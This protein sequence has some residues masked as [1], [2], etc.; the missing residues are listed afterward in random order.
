MPIQ[1][2][3]SVGDVGIIKD[4]SAHEL[5]I[6]AW[7]DGNNVEFVNGYVKQCLGYS[8]YTA[9]GT[10]YDVLHM[11]VYPSLSSPSGSYTIAASGSDLYAA[12]T[13]TF[14][15]ITRS[16]GG[17]YSGQYNSWTSTVLS[18]I[19]IL[20]EGVNVPQYW[21]SN[22]AHVFAPL[23]NWPA[24]YTCA[25]LRAYKNYLFALGVV[26]S[27]T[28]YPYLVK[29]SHPADPGSVPISW[30]QSDPSIDAGEFDLSDSGGYVIDGL[31]LRDS[32]IIYK[33]NSAWRTDYI[34]GAFVFKFSRI[35]GLDGIANRNCVVDIG[36]RHVVLTNNDLV[37]HDG[38]NV[39]SVLSNRVRADF[40]S[41]LYFEAS[42]S[43][44]GTLAHLF[45][46]P[47][48]RSVY[49]AYLNSTKTNTHAL[50]W[51]YESDVISFG[52]LPTSFCGTSGYVYAGT[53]N[54]TMPTTYPALIGA[55][56]K[57]YLL[58][59]QQNFAGSAISS[60][61]ER[62]GLVF[63]AP[64]K[65]K[66]IK[67]ILPRIYG[68]AGQTMTIKCGSQVDPYTAPATWQSNTFTIGTT[69]RVPFTVDGRYIA[70]RIETGTATNWRLDSYSIEYDL[71]GTY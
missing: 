37:V 20:N 2:I 15:N 27:G 63:G 17:S 4:L 5:P 26:K 10:P 65:R 40:I 46:C 52:D 41:R 8:D 47:V 31:Q 34:G 1:H 29:W 33:Q 30:D 18:G 68:T 3:P 51:N 32:F 67:A 13:T 43:R 53:S 25:T 48:R 12:T 57:I 62:R 61:L 49:V 71:T 16:S 19:P 58:D 22:L 60:Y 45:H 42:L 50:I 69:E 56:N 9:A 39:K 6:N 64:E 28:L 55:S 24:G 21:D 11:L 44:P 14:V 23:P 35:D 66:I 59:G 70:I 54:A 36:G 38:V 7:T